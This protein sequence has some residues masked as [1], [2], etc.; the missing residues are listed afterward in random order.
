MYQPMKGHP[1]IFISKANRNIVE[2]TPPLFHVSAIMINRDLKA[3][4][5][6]YFIIWVLFLDFVVI[7]TP[8]KEHIARSPISIL[9]HTII[10]LEDLKPKKVVVAKVKTILFFTSASKGL[11][12]FKLKEGLD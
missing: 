7:S 11:Y 1:P 10:Q 2:V 3:C 12:S 5:I 4:T 9:I 6:K 8:I